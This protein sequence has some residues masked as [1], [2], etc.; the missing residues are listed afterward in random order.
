[1][2]GKAL[3]ME[4]CDDVGVDPAGPTD[5]SRG[6]QKVKADKGKNKAAGEADASEASEEATTKK[7]TVTT[8]KK[9]ATAGKEE[10]TTAK[11]T[12]KPKAARSGKAV[13]VGTR[14]N[15][16]SGLDAPNAAPPPATTKLTNTTGKIVAISTGR[17]EDAQVAKAS[18]ADSRALPVA[19]PT[20]DAFVFP[21]APTTITQ[22]PSTIA[23]L[24]RLLPQI[25]VKL[26]VDSVEEEA[27]DELALLA[28]AAVPDMPRYM[29]K[30]LELLLTHRG[31]ITED[32]DDSISAQLEWRDKALRWYLTHYRHFAPAMDAEIVVDPIF[33]PFDDMDVDPES[34]PLRR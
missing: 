8:S 17:K 29:E 4:D 21:P 1:M 27:E 13:T 18:Q 24:E 14:A 2:L 33:G 23:E 10:A 3:E 20:N 6:K 11:A 25:H 19:P 7:K 5:A 31:A 16:V 15:K 32:D 30:S 28:L 12:T 9:A 22:L 34:V 26:A